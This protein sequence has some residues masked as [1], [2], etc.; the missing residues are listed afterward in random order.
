MDKFKLL[1]V[2]DEILIRKA[3]VR[4]FRAEPIEVLEAENGEEALKILATVPV[5]MVIADH[6]MP[7]MDGLELL[8]LVRER[9]PDAI[10]I[11]LTGFG[12]LETAMQAINQ[13]D[14]FRFFTKPWN[15]DELLQS[16]Q[17]ALKLQHMRVSNRQ[18]IRDLEEQLE[19]MKNNVHDEQP[20]D[21]KA[22]AI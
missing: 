21:R 17:K 14:V 19:R 8:H 6:K 5:S 11:M 1:V 13:G 4:L 16:V 7:G 12:D 9:Y 18:L 2:D 10:R 15:K 20:D 3:L 22:K